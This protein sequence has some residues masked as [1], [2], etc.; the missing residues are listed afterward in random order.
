MRHGRSG[1]ARCAGLHRPEISLE[2]IRRDLAMW[3]FITARIRRWILFAVAI[4]LLTS[5][6][7]RVR[8]LLEKRS[9]ETRL[10]RVLRTLE[11]I[12]RRDNRG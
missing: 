4:P 8:V 9:G 11:G 10:T 1:I 7:R 2:C 3:L 6:I 12:G 5:L